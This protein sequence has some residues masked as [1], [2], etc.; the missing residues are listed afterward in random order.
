MLRA[1]LAANATALSASSP[2]PRPS[3]ELTH[4]NIVQVYAD[5][6]V[7]TAC[8]TWP[9]STSRA[10]TCASTS[11]ARGRPSVLLALSIMRQV[12]AALQR[13]SELGII[14]RDIK[15]E[16]ILLT[17]KGEVKVADFGLSRCFDGR[18][19]R[20]QPDAE[21]R[22]DGHAAVHEPRAGRGQA[23]RLRAPTSTRSASPAT[24]C[25]PASRRSAAAPPSRWPCSTSATSRQPLATIRPDLPPELCAVVHKMMAKEP[26]HR[27]QT[28]R[29][30][31]RDIA[32]VRESLADTNVSSP[33]VTI[34]GETMP[35]ETPAK[36]A[37]K[38]T[39]LRGAGA[40]LRCAVAG[41]AG[42]VPPGI[43]SFECRHPRDSRRRQ[44]YGRRQGRR[45]DRRQEGGGQ[46]G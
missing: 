34:I 35:D 33:A 17:R 3:P 19:S 20:P 18:R 42:A 12:A 6:R 16:N 44:R 38:R 43:Q 39:G 23:G 24:T 28:G 4:A 2:R 8:T 22:D 10:A 32:S 46:E 45:E 36:P 14:H 1:D 7:A 26:A 31:L 29:D 21:R 11:A 5:R 9:W 25:S 13:A 15:P 27:Y 37:R 40:R 30:L 41:G